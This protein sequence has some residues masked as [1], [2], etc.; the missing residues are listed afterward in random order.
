MHIMWPESDRIM[1]TLGSI[2]RRSARD[3]QLRYLSKL[4]LKLKS[5]RDYYNYISAHAIEFY[6][7]LQNSFLRCMQS[8]F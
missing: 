6:K 7:A 4:L 3:L 8:D 1:V 5:G 2:R